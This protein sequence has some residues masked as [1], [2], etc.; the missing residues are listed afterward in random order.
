[1]IVALVEEMLRLQK[2]HAQAEALKEDCRH[3]LACRIE[4]LDAEIDSLVYEL[5]GLMEEEIGVVEATD[6]SG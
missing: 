2:E 4:R 6:G 3:D 5:C 1:M